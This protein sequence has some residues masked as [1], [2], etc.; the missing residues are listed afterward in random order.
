MPVSYAR[1][2]INNRP[3]ASC[4]GS[5]VYSKKFRAGGGLRHGPKRRIV[6][7]HLNRRAVVGHLVNAQ[8]LIPCQIA[9]RSTVLQR[10]A[11]RPRRAGGAGHRSAFGN[12][13]SE[14]DG[15][16]I[17]DDRPVL[18]LDDPRPPVC[19]V[20]GEFAAMG[21]LVDCNQLILRIPLKRAGAVGGEIAIR[22]NGSTYVPFRLS[23][24]AATTRTA[25]E[26]A[27]DA[28]FSYERTRI[29]YQGRRWLTGTSTPCSPARSSTPWPARSDATS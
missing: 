2:C 7:P 3:D 9:R 26:R 16:L 14:P 1:R 29:G 20:I 19:A 13:V 28:G 24:R 27:T 6:V 23:K 10:E 5:P 15:G 4:R 11:L 21:A 18:L 12:L 17:T 22:V 25:R 8:E